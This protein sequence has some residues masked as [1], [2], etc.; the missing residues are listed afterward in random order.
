MNHQEAKSL[1]S[2]KLPESSLSLIKVEVFRLSW[3]GKGYNIIAEET[4]YDHDYV[5]KAGSQ[6]WAEL[7][8]ILE[9]TVNKRNFRTI[10]E[11]ILQENHQ[12]NIKQPDFPGTTIAFSSPFYIERSSEEARS[13]N[14]I[15][16][17][18][19]IVRI[20]GPVKM[21]KSSL[22][23]RVADHANSEGMAQVVIDFNKADRKILSDTDLLL[24]W[25]C[26]QTTLQLNVEN[27]L[28]DYWHD[29]I[30]SKI[31]CSNYIE[32]YVLPQINSPILFI[33]SDIDVIFDFEDTYKDFFPLLRSWHEESKHNDNFKEIRQ[34]LIYS[35]EAYTQLDINLSPFNVGL[36]IELAPFTVEQIT[37]LCHVYGF[38][39][40]NDGGMN[41]PITLI[42]KKLG[43]HPYLT[44]LTLY[45][46][47][48]SEGALESPSAELTN[49]LNNAHRSSGI[50][51]DFLKQLLHLFIGNQHCQQAL[52][53]LLN[54][55]T[56]TRQEISLLENTGIIR[57]SNDSPVVIS[58][59]LIK[60][61]KEHCHA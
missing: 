56:L 12:K 60:Y 8:K 59:V 28:D 19:A 13:Y 23:H 18:G 33:F 49:I 47:S 57:M 48:T 22:M 9:Q 46:L 15:M 54:N 32:Q 51:G 38:S 29:I 17:P 42:L 40:T 2:V 5:R 55:D 58:P 6:L 30:G 1:L 14:E 21:G 53:R 52:L 7:T 26:I 41:S 31:C 24:K 45:H 39:W 16:K 4:G 43:G 44:Q 35:T 50:F 3:Q 34:L 10:M 11:S 61:L 37:Q 25:L 27:K 20:K 36:P